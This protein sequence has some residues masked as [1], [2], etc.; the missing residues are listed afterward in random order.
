MDPI[1]NKFINRYNITEQSYKRAEELGF[2][3]SL[4]DKPR[5]KLCVYDPLQNTTIYIGGYGT[6][7]Y[8]DYLTLE[9]KNYY[10]KGYAELRR[11]QY[12]LNKIKINH[13]NNLRYLYNKSINN[14]K[15]F[16]ID[17]IL[18]GIYDVPYYEKELNKSQL[19]IFDIPS[20]TLVLKN[21]KTFYI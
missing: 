10:K 2:E 12:K 11:Q 5:Y 18:W 7:A 9:N 8:Y 15:T 21:K 17:Y 13:Y 19:N 1:P 4:S 20:S 16:L 6:L 3:L 14:Y